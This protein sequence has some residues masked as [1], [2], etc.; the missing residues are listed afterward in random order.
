MRFERTGDSRSKDD[1]PE[2]MIV[3]PGGSFNVN[4]AE[5]CGSAHGF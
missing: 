3:Y 1:P 2:S 4:A 5:P